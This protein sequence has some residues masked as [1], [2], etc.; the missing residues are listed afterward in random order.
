MLRRP[1]VG[2]RLAKLLRTEAHE[3]HLFVAIGVGGIGISQYLAMMD[4]PERLPTVAPKVPSGISHLWLTT[5]YGT[6]VFGWTVD[7]WRAHHVLGD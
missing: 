4:H 5:G 2:R 6:V 1:A 3:R 7:G